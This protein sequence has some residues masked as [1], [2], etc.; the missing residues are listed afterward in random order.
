MFLPP[1]GPVFLAQ[2]LGPANHRIALRLW[3]LVL[4]RKGHGLFAV[5]FQSPLGAVNP[6]A[7]SHEIV[8][9]VAA[10]IHCHAGVTVES[11]DHVRLVPAILVVVDSTGS[12]GL[13]RRGLQ[14]QHGVDSGQD[15]HIEVAGQPF[16]VIRVAPPPEEALGIKGYLGRV[17]QEAFPVDRL[18]AGVRRNRIDPGTA[19]V[20]P[21]HP[22]IDGRDVAQSPALN[23]LPR[24][25]KDN[26]AP[27]LAAH[28][29]PA[30]VLFHR[31]DNLEAFLDLVRH[32]LFAINVLAGCAGVFHDLGVPVVHGGHNDKVDVLAVKN[33]TV[34]FGGVE[35][36]AGVLLGGNQPAVVKVGDG[37]HLNPGGAKRGG[38]VITTPNSCADGS[39]SE[40]VRRWYGPRRRHCPRRFQH[41]HLRCRTDRGGA[42]S[43]SHEISPCH[44]IFCHKGLASLRKSANE[45][46]TFG[47]TGKFDRN[48]REVKAFCSRNLRPPCASA[49]GSPASDAR[50]FRPCFVVYPSTAR[51]SAAALMDCS[52]RPAS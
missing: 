38:Q 15:V 52:T 17:T 35:L 10:D 9:Q 8:V 2:L 20:V 30:V 41:R 47:V 51:R 23:N 39:K 40:P 48:P 44:R 1:V 33:S 25:G 32:R 28:L 29:H 49:D 31:V 22:A 21:V 50:S 4:R 37:H 46:K 5:K 12:H 24:F 11:G 6:R 3:L 27:P 19:G 14:S 18:R 7:A 45:I 13:L 34:V 16:A 43:Y 36:L 42:R 26:V